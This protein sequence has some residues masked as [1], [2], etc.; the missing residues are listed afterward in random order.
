V[1]FRFKIKSDEVEDFERIIDID[2]DASFLELHQAI[3]A[4]TAYKDNINIS[5][6]LCD[7]DWEKEKEVCIVDH[8]SSYEEDVW[9]MKETPLNELIDD[10]GR[11][12]IYVFDPE[13]ERF[14]FIE[15]ARIITGKSVEGPI[16][17]A[18][19][20]KAPNQVLKEE[21]VKTA[22]TSID[23]DADF[24]GDKSYNTEDLSNADI[25]DDLIDLQP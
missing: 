19:S 6:F 5:F 24:Y 13:N 22:A 7:D 18:E 14:I 2:P 3:L 8:G 23:L 25:H 4:A 21:I 15:L 11:R 10:E 20:G 9:L 17:V 1:I 12:L 16:C